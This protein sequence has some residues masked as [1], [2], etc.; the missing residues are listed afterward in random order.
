VVTRA[1]TNSQHRRN[2]CEAVI[3]R[4]SVGC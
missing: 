1:V 4:L 3:F 2:Q